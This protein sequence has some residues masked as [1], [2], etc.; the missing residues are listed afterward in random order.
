MRERTLASRLRKLSSRCRMYPLS[1]FYIEKVSQDQF[2]ETFLMGH[3]REVS[4]AAQEDLADMRRYPTR[5]PRSAKFVLQERHR[6]AN[7]AS[8]GHEV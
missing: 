1:Q 3:V 6:A 8:T 5:L 2:S 7:Q 4:K